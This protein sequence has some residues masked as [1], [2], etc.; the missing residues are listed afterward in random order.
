MHKYLDENLGKGYIPHSTSPAEHSVLLIFK[1][2]IMDKNGKK[3][4]RYRVYIDFK[5]INAD[6][7]KNR[8]SLF[9]IGEMKDRLY[10]AQ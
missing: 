10:Q 6:T 3:K 9:F 8:Y 1:K 5:L 4:K 7:V 2:S